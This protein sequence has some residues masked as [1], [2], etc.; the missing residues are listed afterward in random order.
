MIPDEHCTVPANCICPK[1]GTK[2]VHVKGTPCEKM[3]CPKCRSN[4]AMDKCI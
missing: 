2:V 4:M 3:T 1:C